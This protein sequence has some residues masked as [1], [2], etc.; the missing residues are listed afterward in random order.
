[1]LKRMCLENI[2]CGDG[3][4]VG[5]VQDWCN[6]VVLQ[7][8]RCENLTATNLQGLTC[9]SHLEPKYLENLKTL[10]FTGDGSSSTSIFLPPLQFV[11]IDGLSSL[12]CLL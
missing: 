6:V 3:F 10:T 2:R 9:L 12:E 8:S 1:M 11:T 7:I 4:P 5:K